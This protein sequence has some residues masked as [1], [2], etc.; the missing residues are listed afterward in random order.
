MLSRKIRFAVWLSALALGTLV[1]AQASVGFTSESFSLDSQ[2]ALAGSLHHGASST[3]NAQLSSYQI[4]LRNV[5]GKPVVTEDCHNPLLPLLIGEGITGSG[6]NKSEPPAEFGERPSEDPAASEWEYLWNNASIVPI[7][8]VP[9]PSIAA[10][11]AI[12]AIL[13]TRRNRRRN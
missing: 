11:L 6:L 12:G 2:I 7:N 5:N 3:P 8:A 1:P 4:E 9:E 13:V 10:L